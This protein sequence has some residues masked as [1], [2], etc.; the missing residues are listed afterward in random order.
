MTDTN[1]THTAALELAALGYRILP[2]VSKSKRPACKH[3]CEDAT[4]NEAIIDGWWRENPDYN[5]GIATDGMIVVDI[6]GADNPWPK[7]PEKALELAAPSAKTQ[8][9]GQHYFFRQPDE[10]SFRNSVAK[11]AVGTEVQARANGGVPRR[12]I[13]FL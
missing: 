9:G 7:D 4:T 5:I 6:D 12:R 1:A 3:G 13:W 10:G 2:V 11:L 8:S